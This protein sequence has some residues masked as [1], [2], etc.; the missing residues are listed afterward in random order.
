MGEKR[1]CFVC[2]KPIK[3]AHMYSLVLQSLRNGERIPKFCSEYCIQIW[4]EIRGVKDWESWCW[5]NKIPVC[6]FLRAV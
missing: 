6:D 2:R 3:K 5:A 1:Y 4:L